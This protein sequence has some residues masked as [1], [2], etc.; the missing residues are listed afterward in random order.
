M[1]IT[2]TTDNKQEDFKLSDDFIKEYSSDREV[3][4]FIQK[5]FKRITRVSTIKLI[6]HLILRTPNIHISSLKRKWKTFYQ[7][8]MSKFDSKYNLKIEV[9]RELR[10]SLYGFLH[11][12][13]KDIPYYNSTETEILSKII[14]GVD[15]YVL[16][17]SISFKK[18]RK[19]ICDEGGELCLKYN[20]VKPD[21]EVSIPANK[22]I[23]Q[24]CNIQIL[25]MPI[26]FD[27]P[28]ENEYRCPQCSNVKKLKAY[29]VAST[30]GKV[31]CC[32]LDSYIH[33]ESGEPKTKRCM[34]TLFPDT[35]VSLTK[36]AYYY[37]ICY[38]DENDSKQTAGAFSFEQYEPGFYECVLFKIKNPKKTEL[39]QLIDIKNIV[40]NKFKL[41]EQLDNTN[42]IISLQKA[43]D[44][45]IKKQTG[46][47]IYGLNPI[48]IAMI[49]Q[50]MLK[51]LGLKLIGN[52]Q[53]VGDAS[54]GKT[55]VLKYYGF[56]L[57]N[58]L[59][60]STSGLN[61]SIP[62]MRGTKQ[63]ITL[64]GRDQKI[65]TP[66]YLGT[67]Y[68]I[69]IDE[70]GEN[71]E[72]TQNLKTFL[73]EDN[74][75]YNKAGATGVSNKRVA[76]V[77]L[78]ENLDY[79]HLGQ[80]RGAIRKSYKD[81][82]SKIGDEIKP[83][84]NEDEDL[85]LPLFKYINN[86]YLYKVISDKRLE[87]KLKQVFW[88]DGYEHAL[89]ERFP[90]YFYLVNEDENEELIK[91]V[92]GN[93]ARNS[94]SENLELIKALK[95][96]DI[97]NYFKSLK[98]YVNS[99]L[100][101]S[102]FIKVDKILKQY[103]LKADAR[104]KTFYYNVVKISRIINKRFEVIEQDYNLLKWI[105]EKTNC[106]LEIAETV[107]YDIIGPPDIKEQNKKQLEIEDAVK[108]VNDNNSFGMPEDEF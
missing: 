19:L 17:K 98:K 51:Y 54:T 23:L 39:F 13:G 57:N 28:I 55:T 6:K 80:Y 56:L 88:I 30:N 60:L 84:W 90:F 12:I 67:F 102:S 22:D 107:N 21:L 95:T 65:V 1:T 32:G 50:V 85:H 89:H 58:H 35:E 76:Q 14:D 77:N 68:S 59:N 97:V 75:G 7:Y 73:L 61:V 99:D 46:M 36:D 3:V 2:N 92:R 70:A 40:C 29:E 27:Y 78:S 72:L 86:P 8:N 9:I 82:D 10:T 66:G 34:C 104:T 11:E 69:H 41:P 44:K 38:E 45:Y 25:S 62:G 18:V 37:D 63:T 74:Y 42:Y 96:D 93:V 24:R 101:V 43:F 79:N 108:E 33:P 49:M 26:K 48:K 16:D 100:D 31:Y 87:Y 64:M 91:V 81:F 105:I 47:E 53:V 5:R 15:C 71:K 4:N 94:I 20:F 83:E 106:K 52:I 103:D